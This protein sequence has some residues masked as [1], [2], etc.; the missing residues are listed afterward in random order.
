M[1]ACMSSKD[2]PPTADLASRRI[3]SCS[4]V[5]LMLAFSE[6]LRVERLDRLPNHLRPGED[7]GFN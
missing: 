2:W 4:G 1:Q 7:Y 6:G 5:A 3:P